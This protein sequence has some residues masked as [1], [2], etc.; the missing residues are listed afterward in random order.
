MTKKQEILKWMNYG[1]PRGK[2]V[3]IFEDMIDDLVAEAKRE[4]GERILEDI[5]KWSKTVTVTETTDSEGAK[6]ATRKLREN[7]AGSYHF[8]YQAIKLTQDPCR[9]HCTEIMIPSFGEG[10]PPKNILPKTNI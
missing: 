6:K 7:L 1:I 10:N 3:P 2:T 9:K 5:L 4:E 8:L